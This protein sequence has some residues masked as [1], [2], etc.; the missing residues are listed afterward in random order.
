ME[1]AGAV[2]IIT[3]SGYRNGSS[4]HTGG[5]YWACG[6]YSNNGCGS[7]FGESGGGYANERYYGESVRLIQNY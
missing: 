6:Y 1:N 3:E 4:Y 7:G 5:M 2:F